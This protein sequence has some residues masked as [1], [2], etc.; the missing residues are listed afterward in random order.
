MF[1]LILDIGQDGTGLAANARFAR[2]AAALMLQ[3]YQNDYRPIAGNNYYNLTSSSA[4]DLYNGNIS[5]LST[6]YYTETPLLKSFRY[7]KLNRIKRMQ[8]AS[9][10]A[11][12]WV[13]FHSMFFLF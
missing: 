6:D 7:D 2:D 5:C 11:G 9:I 1:F 3:Y 12:E 4:T 8:T 13:V 10:S